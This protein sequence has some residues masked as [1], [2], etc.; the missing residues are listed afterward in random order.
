MIG[1]AFGVDTRIENT[2]LR[3]RQPVLREKRLQGGGADLV[4][5]NIEEDLHGGLVCVLAALE[6]SGHCFDR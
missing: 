6:E 4:V 1:K 3:Q 5:A 2:G